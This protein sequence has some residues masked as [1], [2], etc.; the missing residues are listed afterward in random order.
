MKLRLVLPV[1]SLAVA[2]MTLAVSPS[3][4]AGPITTIDFNCSDG[5]G[6]TTGNKSICASPTTETLV[7]WTQGAFSVSPTNGTWF[8]NFFQ[9]NPSPSL[10]ATGGG[11]VSI[12]DGGSWFRFDSVDL[13]AA[14]A[15]N[16]GYTFIGKLD[17]STVFDFGCSGPTCLSTSFATELAGLYGNDNINSLTINLIGGGNDR[18]DNIDVTGVPEPSGLL[19]LG[20]GILAL[21]FFVRRKLVA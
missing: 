8:Y 6:T 19:L 16:T 21:A 3:A 13:E 12:T 11:T 15:G 5:S 10:S 20:T 4:F 17:G 2:A 18:V 9:G 1:F 14:G 7:S